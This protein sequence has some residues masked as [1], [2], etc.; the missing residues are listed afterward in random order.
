MDALLSCGRSQ[1]IKPI[2]QA[3]RILA[4]EMLALPSAR[5]GRLD[6]RQLNALLRLGNGFYF[7]AIRMMR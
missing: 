6:D 3:G 4:G 2:T 5:Y 7:V 1:L